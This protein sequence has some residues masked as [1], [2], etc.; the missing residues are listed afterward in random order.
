MDLGR[1]RR[2]ADEPVLTDD[3]HVPG[4]AEQDPV[5][6]Q[7]TLVALPP[8]AAVDQEYP[9]ARR[10]LTR[11]GVHVAAQVTSTARAEHH[12]LADIDPVLGHG[13]SPSR[14]GR[15]A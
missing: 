8:A 5:A 9:R 3:A 6:A 15:T 2:L 13:P 7:L 12:V 10:L 11:G 14:L 1:P 4:P